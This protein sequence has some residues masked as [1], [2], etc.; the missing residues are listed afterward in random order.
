[1]S[2]RAMA[3]DPPTDVASLAFLRLLCTLVVIPFGGDGYGTTE[4]KLEG[5]DG[6]WMGKRVDFVKTG[7]IGIVETGPVAEVFDIFSPFAVERE[8][9][10]VM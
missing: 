1:M 9:A 4:D 6:Y 5:E 2:V 7:L 3:V 8:E 10:T